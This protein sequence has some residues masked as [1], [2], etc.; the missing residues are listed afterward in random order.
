MTDP[1]G[2]AVSFTI[3]GVPQQQGSKT[4]TPQG[5][6]REA[7]RNLAPWRKVALECAR[8]AKSRLPGAHD[9]APIFAGPVQVTMTAYFPRPAG[10]FGTGRNAGQLKVSAPTW[11]ASA[12]DL[13]K[14]ARACGDM[15]TQSGILQDDRLIVAWDATK[16]YGDPRMTVTVATAAA[17]HLMTQPEGCARCGRDWPGIPAGN[18]N[19]DVCDTCLAAVTRAATTTS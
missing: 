3:P 4:R 2:L 9:G 13:D 15:L 10:H 16:L 5:F 14:V 6:S 18:P 19:L 1:P 7:N 11:H 17:S 12:P 8:D